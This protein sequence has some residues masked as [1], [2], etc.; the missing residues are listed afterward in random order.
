MSRNAAKVR[1]HKAPIN[2]LLSGFNC[3][4]KKIKKILATTGNPSLRGKVPF[5]VRI[6]EDRETSTKEAADAK[7]KTQVYAD[8]SAI[9]SKVGAAAV[10]LREGKPQCALHLHLSPKSEHTVH[11][12]KLVGILL[13]LQLIYMEK[14]AATSCMIR[15]DNQAA[16]QAFQADPRSPGQHITREATQMAKRIQNC[17]RG[18]EYT[19]T[20]R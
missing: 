12:A 1:R 10:L 14:K 4:I 11:K 9:N 15:V 19:L 8:G 17:R 3:E 6:A 5:Q 2:H 7:E 13:G 20:L 18:T 16:L